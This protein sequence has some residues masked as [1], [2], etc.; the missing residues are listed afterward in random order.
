MNVNVPATTD[1]DGDFPQTIIE[2]LQR[3]RELI[4]DLIQTTKAGN[5]AEAATIAAALL[6]LIAFIAWMVDGQD[7]VDKLGIGDLDD[8]PQ[9]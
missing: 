2:H 8:R 6:S 9:G 3:M 1:D 7:G 4:P 5:D